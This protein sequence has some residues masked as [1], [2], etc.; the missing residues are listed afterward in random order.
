HQYPYLET[1]PDGLHTEVQ[2]HGG[3]AA[4]AIYFWPDHKHHSG[5]IRQVGPK[6]GG[7]TCEGWKR[8]LG[9]LAWK[10]KVARRHCRY[11]DTRTC[12]RCRLVLPVGESAYSCYRNQRLTRAKLARSPPTIAAPAANQASDIAPGVQIDA[13]ASATSATLT[14]NTRATTS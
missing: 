5:P 1:K 6:S 11:C 7:R 10:S 4:P 14:A 13:S 2:H 9:K 8:V 12:V 3:Q